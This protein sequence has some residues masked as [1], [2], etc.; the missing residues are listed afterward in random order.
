MGIKFRGFAGLLVLVSLGLLASCSNKSSSSSS[1]GPGTLFVTTQGDTSVSAFSVDP[2]TGK[3]TANGTGLATGSTPSAIVLTPSGDAAFVTNRG[4]GDISRYTVASGGT[5]TAVS[6]A[7]AAGTNPMGMAI[8][9]NGSFLFVA[10]QGTGVPG[11]STISVFSISGT[12][13]AAVGAP[14][15][16]AD[17]AVAVAI[18]PDGKYLYVANQFAN[19]IS[20]YSVD[21][22][23]ALTPVPGSP[24]LA[25]TSPS[26]LVVSPAGSFLYV[27]NSG[28]DNISA[29]TICAVISNT[30]SVADGGLVPFPATFPAG[31]KP[32]S[33]ALTPSGDF[34]YVA[35]WQSNQVSGYAVSV[36]SGTLTPTSQNAISTGVNPT[37]VAVHPGAG[38]LYTANIG[39]PS[40]SVFTLNATT[41]ALGTDGT[42]VSTGPLPSAIA[43]K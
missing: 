31:L 16:T 34:L 8:D 10:N 24:Y 22:T 5:L 6:G 43:L 29:F 19:L 42:A 20:A 17:G 12:T 28:S 18:T 30:C 4:T 9:T 39:G 38:F 33:L 7:Q 13:L 36:A 2:S 37:W 23:G 26:A 21:S 41:G 11:S 15:A 40:I 25:G 14:V 1:S 3:I 32:V 35:D 27:A